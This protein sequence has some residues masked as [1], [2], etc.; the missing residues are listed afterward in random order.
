MKMT[1]SELAAFDDRLAGA[2][3]GAKAPA[4][5]LGIEQVAGCIFAACSA[6]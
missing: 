3:P 2:K 4:R 1:A 6:Y 5:V